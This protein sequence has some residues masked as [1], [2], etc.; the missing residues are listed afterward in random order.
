[1]ADPGSQDDEFYLVTP[2]VDPD[3]RVK[4]G[5]YY[6]WTVAWNREPL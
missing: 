2:E 3:E 5:K 4:R 6:T 1:V